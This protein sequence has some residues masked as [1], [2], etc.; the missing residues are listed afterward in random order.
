MTADDLRSFAEEVAAAFNAG[1]IRAPIHLDG[2]NEQ[3]LIDVFKTIARQDWV[4]GSWRMMSKGLLH[5]VPRDEL[6]ASVLAGHSIT[7]CFPQH[8]V[9][10]SAI[11]GGI[12]PIALG[13]AWQIKRSG[14]PNRV[15]CFMGDMTAETGLY[16][17]CE[18]YATGWGLPIRFVIEDNGKSVCTPTD[19]TWFGAD[20]LMREQVRRYGYDLPWP[21]SGAGKRVEF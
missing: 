8:R 15:H 4:C 9:I 7:L 19:A 5:G 12:L 6:L 2:G 14:S 11:V 13:I 16:W 21:H 3:Q 10:S 1:K 20:P 18:K 17:E